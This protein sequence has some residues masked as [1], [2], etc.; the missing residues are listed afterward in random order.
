MNCKYRR[1]FAFNCTQI[2][3]VKIRSCAV[4]I[5]KS[6]LRAV[7]EHIERKEDKAKMLN[8]VLPAFI[9][10]LI[11]SLNAPSGQTSS[12]EMKTE[13]VKGK[14]KVKFSFLEFFFLFLILVKLFICI[15]FYF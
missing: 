3:A 5:F 10:K 1:P 9:D 4:T 6:L 14:V 12:F 11:I 2:Y 13:I 7:N 15:F 8:P